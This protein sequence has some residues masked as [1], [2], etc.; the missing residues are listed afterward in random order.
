MT[1]NLPL[2]DDG[3]IDYEQLLI[4]H[5]SDGGPY[6]SIADIVASTLE[7]VA[8]LA[9]ECWENGVPYQELST[10]IRAMKP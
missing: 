3:G 5:P 4:T 8:K 7:R 6:C 10:R 1:T 9:D 2:R